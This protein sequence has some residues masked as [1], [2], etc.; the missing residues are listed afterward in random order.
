[1]HPAHHHHKYH[2]PFFMLPHCFDKPF[3]PVK[4]SRQPMQAC[5]APLRNLILRR[6][7][8]NLDTDRQGFSSSRPFNRQMNAALRP[9]TSILES[10]YISCLQD[11]IHTKIYLQTVWGYLVVKV[12]VSIVKVG[13]VFSFRRVLHVPLLR[14]RFDFI[15]H[16]LMFLKI[17]LFNIGP[18]SQLIYSTTISCS[19]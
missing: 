7:P 10:Y 12:R 11:L 15:D 3:S 8:A 9:P 18:L 4:I 13:Y 16:L 6:S 19:R 5:R 2:G 1:M 17:G 14:F